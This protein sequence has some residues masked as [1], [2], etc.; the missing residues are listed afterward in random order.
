MVNEQLYIYWN[1][2]ISTKI[3]NLNNSVNTNDFKLIVECQSETPVYIVKKKK[4]KLKRLG[5]LTLKVNFRIM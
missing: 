2:L 3:N 4:K 5:M 1:T